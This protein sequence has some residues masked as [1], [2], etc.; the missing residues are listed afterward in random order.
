[1]IDYSTVLW[2]EVIGDKTSKKTYGAIPQVRETIDLQRFARHIAAH[3]SVYGRGDIYSVLCQAVDCIREQLL[4]GNNV[5]LG[6]LGT[7]ALTFR[8][9]LQD[10]REDVTAQST[11]REVNVRFIPG[12]A[13]GTMRQDAEFN[14]VTSREAQLLT[15]KAEKANLTNTDIKKKTEK[16]PLG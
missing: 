2:Y 1:M 15:R 10:N 9:N 4:A 8:C 14:P 3:G 7:F 12:K 6:D 13:F 16:P 11:I 5:Q